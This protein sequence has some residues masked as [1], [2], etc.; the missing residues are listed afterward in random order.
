VSDADAETR[1]G[2]VDS[3]D[4]TRFSIKG[5]LRFGPTLRLVWNVSP[6]WTIVNVVLAVVQGLLPL[7]GILLLGLI[8][9]FVQTTAT[10]AVKQPLGAAAEAA[11]FRHVAFLIVVAGV[12]GLVTA[13]ARSVSTLVGEAQGQVVTDHHL[14]HHPR[15]V[16][17][18]R[19]RVLR[20]LALLRR[21]APRPAGG[22]L[23][24][25]QDRQRPRLD[26]PEPDQPGRRDGCCCSP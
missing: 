26:R 20:E 18:G 21:P 7:L 8:V 23:P 10:A 1:L 11:A 17:R 19:P 13:L 9:N 14:R 12:V 15:Q 24:P 25:D 4:E 16:H 6:V 22:A 5:A 2:D 3:D